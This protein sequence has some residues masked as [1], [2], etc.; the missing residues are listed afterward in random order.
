MCK[1]KFHGLTL[2][3]MSYDKIKK[4]E[5]LKLTALNLFCAFIYMNTIPHEINLINLS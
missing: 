5:N 1:V 3:L 2:K 4:I